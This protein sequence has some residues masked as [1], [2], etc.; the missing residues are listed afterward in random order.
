MGAPASPWTPPYKLDACTVIEQPEAPAIPPAPALAPASPH[1]QPQ[2]PTFNYEST[3]PVRP[4]APSAVPDL[5]PLPGSLDTTEL[6]AL[7]DRY[8][9]AGYALGRFHAKMGMPDSLKGR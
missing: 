3:P 4:V 1:Y 8:W 5:A 7:L 2:S 9:S 6:Q